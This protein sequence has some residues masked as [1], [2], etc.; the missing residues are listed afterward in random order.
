MNR[1]K[2]KARY[3][4]HRNTA[5]KRNIPFL[6]TFE[7]WDKW[8]LSNGVDKDLP[9]VFTNRNTLNMCRY[10]DTGAYELNNI[11]CATYQ[12]NRKDQKINGGAKQKK[13]STP[14][15]I[16]ESRNA[17]AAHYMIDP[18]TINFR[19]KKNPKEWFYV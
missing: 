10:N 15:G 7:E 1:K 9:T 14:D 6:L 4:W 19:M 2:A 18:A 17:A 13:L 5:R 12:Q 11:Y 16:F 3:C 8:W